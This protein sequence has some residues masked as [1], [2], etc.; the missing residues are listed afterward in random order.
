MDQHLMKRW[1]SHILT[2]R[3]R[4][5]KAGKRGLLIFDGFRAHL[6]KDVTDLVVENNFDVWTLP[7]NT[8]P[9]LQPL[10]I[11]TNRSFKNAFK[12]GLT[13]TKIKTSSLQKVES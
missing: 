6:R 1:I 3:K 8:T 2:K 5:I 10:D 13:R 4:K 12:I 7:P 9:F 11:S